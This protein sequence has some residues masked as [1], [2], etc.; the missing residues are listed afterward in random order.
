MINSYFRYGAKSG[1]FISL[2]II[3]MI[4]ELIKPHLFR[5]KNLCDKKKV[6][7]FASEIKLIESC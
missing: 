7:T 2:K 4:S 6:S 5:K 1:I 3:F